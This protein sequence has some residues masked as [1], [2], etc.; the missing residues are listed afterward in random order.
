L[1]K[2]AADTAD[3]AQSGVFGLHHHVEQHQGDVAITL[4]SISNASAPL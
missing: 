3:Q 2:L 4:R 1:F